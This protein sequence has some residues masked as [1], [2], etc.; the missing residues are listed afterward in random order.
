LRWKLAKYWHIP[1][2][3]IFWSTLHDIQWRIFAEH[4]Q[5]D[6]QEEYERSRN[7][8]EYG[9][10]FHNYE[11]VKAVQEER[12]RQTSLAGSESEDIFL[13]QLRNLGINLDKEALHNARQNGGSVPQD[14]DKDEE[15]TIRVVKRD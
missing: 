3:D 9:M 12:E 7:L 15:D 5:L 14:N 8:V 10:A 4:A 6:Q 11:A 1:Y 13:Q 2:S